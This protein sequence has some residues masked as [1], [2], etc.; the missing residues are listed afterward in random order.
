VISAFVLLNKQV[1]NCFQYTLKR[2]TFANVASVL[3]VVYVLPGRA[4]T[5]CRWGGS[6]NLTF[7]VTNLLFQQW[8]ND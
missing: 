2:Y 5:E 6:R 3:A 8:K 7:I 1:R 4:V